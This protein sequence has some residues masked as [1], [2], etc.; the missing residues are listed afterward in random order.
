M[1]AVFDFTKVLLALIDLTF[2]DVNQNPPDSSDGATNMSSNPVLPVVSNTMSN[3][4]AIPSLYSANNVAQPP[5]MFT[6]PP[7][8]LPVNPVVNHDANAS[9]VFPTQN[10]FASIPTHYSGSS[11]QYNSYG[12]YGSTY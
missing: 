11:G 4:N 2:V 12:S 10:Q 1:L 5:P 9:N 3:M 6:V 7:P 8:A